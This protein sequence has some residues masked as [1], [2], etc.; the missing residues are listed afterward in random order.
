[1]KLKQSITTSDNIQNSQEAYVRK[2]TF[3]KYVGCFW[4]NEYQQPA[5]LQ[6]SYTKKCLNFKYLT[7]LHHVNCA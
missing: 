6:N 4:D 5:Y 2:E 7:L 3:V 1:M